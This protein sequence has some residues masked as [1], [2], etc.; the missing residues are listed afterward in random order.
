MGDKI[1][2]N[3]TI[4]GL[5][6]TLTDPILPPILVTPRQAFRALAVSD[7]VGYRLIREKVIPTVKLPK[8]P[9]RVP[10]DKLR[11]MLAA[12]VEVDRLCRTCIKRHPQTGKCTVWSS[13]PS[14]V[15]TCTGWS[16]DELWNIEEWKGRVKYEERKG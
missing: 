1:P 11:D 3:T 15:R 13:P 4:R 2:R 5:N 10:V 12:M 9:Q 7:K 14:D 6:T 16:F 8:G